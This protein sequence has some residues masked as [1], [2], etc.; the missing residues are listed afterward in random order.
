MKFFVLGA[1]GM[2]GHTLALYLVEHGHQV[3]G[4]ARQK[5]PV[6]DTVTGDASEIEKIQNIIE[7]EKFDVVVNCIG[8]LNKFVDDDLA[9]GVFVNSYFP[10]IVAKFCGSYGCKMIHISTDCVFSGKSYGYTE[11]DIPDETSYYG[12]TKFLGE[13]VDGNHLTI[14][15]SIVGPELKEKGIGLFHWFMRQKDAVSGYAQV[16]WSGATTLELAKGILAAAKQ[17]VSGLY[18]LSNNTGISKYGLLKLFNH[19]CNGDRVNIIRSEKPISSR[20]LISTRRDVEYNVP[21][22]ETMV[23][24][25]REWI[26]SHKSL[27]S[28]YVL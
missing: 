18:Y 25:M 17:N 22:Y 19:Y 1:T 3:V 24:E 20:V 16:I 9:T 2:A 7:K 5:S 10:H 26:G 11:D 8:I 28:Q 27:Y 23:K 6:C 21:D 14:R 15:T 4:Y 13:V 12:R